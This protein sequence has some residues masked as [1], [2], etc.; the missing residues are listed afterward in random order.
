MIA[1]DLSH[2]QTNISLLRIAMN[3]LFMN[4]DLLIALPFQQRKSLF[5]GCLLLRKV[6]ALAGL[7]QRSGNPL[8]RYVV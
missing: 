4:F 7:K 1:S 3:W 6:Y 8:L 2:R 5:S